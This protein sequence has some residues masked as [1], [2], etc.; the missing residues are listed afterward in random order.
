LH[1]FF[2]GEVGFIV[3]EKDFLVIFSGEAS[4]M[5][6]FSYFVSTLFFIFSLMPLFYYICQTRIPQQHRQL[7]TQNR[8]NQTNYGSGKNN[9]ERQPCL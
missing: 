6:N 8:P 2:Y 7:A 1:L 5:G 3:R 4:S 9:S